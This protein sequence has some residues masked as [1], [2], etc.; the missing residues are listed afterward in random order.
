M[1]ELY[2]V[3]VLRIDVLEAAEAVLLVAGEDERVVEQVAFNLQS[4][5][6]ARLE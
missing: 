3:H 1:F 5:R 6:E 4:D 2:L